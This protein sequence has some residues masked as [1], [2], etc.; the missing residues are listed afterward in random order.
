MFKCKVCIEKD[1]RIQELKDQIAY[2]RTL[3][4]PQNSAF[5]TQSDI[6]DPNIILDA[7]SAAADPEIQKQQRSELERIAQEREAVLAGHLDQVPSIWEGY[8]E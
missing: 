4:I 3:A 1:K 6:L 8:S 2:L 5:D 7:P